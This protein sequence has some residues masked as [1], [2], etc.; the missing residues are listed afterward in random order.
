VGFNFA[1]KVMGSNFTRSIEVGLMLISGNHVSLII[2]QYS[3]NCILEIMEV[4]DFQPKISTVWQY[5]FRGGR[6]LSVPLILIIHF[7]LEFHVN[8]I[9]IIQNQQQL[10]LGGAW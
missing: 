2:I 8:S 6:T 9:A 1:I 4:W 10:G 7:Y 5:R 3:N